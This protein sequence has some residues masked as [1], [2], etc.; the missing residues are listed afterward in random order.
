MSEIEVG[1]WI[2][3]VVDND[4]EIFS[5]YPHSIR[6]KGSDTL[7]RTTINN[8]GY[9]TCRMN[10]NTYLK[11]RVIAQQF[12]PNPNNLLEV[13][14]V[15]HNRC[16]NRIKNLRWI[17]HSD[18]LKNR[19]SAN[20]VDYE[21]RE[22]LSDNT[23]MILEYNGHWLDFY[24]YDEED[25]SFYFYTGVNYRKLHVNYDKK[26]DAAYVNVLDRNNKRVKISYNKFKKMY[27]LI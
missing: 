19:S 22:E 6:R 10:S 1:N 14:H 11:H 8:D 5:E 12:I 20:G 9:V 2:E 3:C 27:D 4:Y 25:D 23:I 7:V 24:Y 18:N 13:D 17:S 15:N 21:Y 16:D 26:C